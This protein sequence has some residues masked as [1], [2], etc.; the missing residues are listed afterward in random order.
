MQGRSPAFRETV[1]G[2]CLQGDATRRLLQ[3]VLWVGPHSPTVRQLAPVVQVCAK[4]RVTNDHR[5]LVEVRKAGDGRPC[6]RG[7]NKCANCGDPMARGQMPA[8][9]RGRP[10]SFPGDRRHRPHR[11]GS[12]R[13]LGQR[14]RPP[15]ERGSQ[16]RRRSRRGREG[17]PRPGRGWSW[18]S[19]EAGKILSFLFFSC[20]YGAPFFFPF[21]LGHGEKEVGEPC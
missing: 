10:A 6:P 4:G 16:A 21:C 18:G 3:P 17:L 11:T 5:C 14:S 7:T 2:R 12:V 9:P 19:R 1:R 20:Y 13:F 8:R 15:R